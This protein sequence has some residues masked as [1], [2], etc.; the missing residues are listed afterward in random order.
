MKTLWM[1]FERTLENL[2]DIPTFTKN[3]KAVIHPLE[4]TS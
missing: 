1:S 2:R 4:A 3:A